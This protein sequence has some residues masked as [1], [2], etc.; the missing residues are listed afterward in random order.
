M[1]VAE[2]LCEE[3][4]WLHSRLGSH[5]FSAGWQIARAE[6]KWYTVTTARLEALLSTQSTHFLGLPESEDSV[7]LALDMLPEVPSHNMHFTFRFADAYTDGGR[8]DHADEFLE[9]LQR[10]L[11]TTQSANRVRD[12]WESLRV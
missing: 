4:G 7:E 8:S 10:G 11:G 2:R 6:D 5:A 12:H 9:L 3:L 1:A